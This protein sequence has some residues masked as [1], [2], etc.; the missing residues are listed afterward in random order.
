MLLITAAAASTVAAG[1]PAHAFSAFRLDRTVRQ[2]HPI[3]FTPAPHKVNVRTEG[4][5]KSARGGGIEIQLTVTPYAGDPFECGTGTSVD[6][7][8]GEQVNICYRL[9]NNTAQTLTHQTVEDSVDGTLM[10]YE[11]HAIPAGQQ[12]Y[13]VR[14]VVATSDTTR[15]ATWTGYS[16]VASYTANDQAAPS[17]VDI[18]TTGTDIGFE[19]GSPD[20]N[21][22]AEVTAGFPIRFYGRESSA[23]CVSIDGFIGY[24]DPVCD[25]PSPGAKPQP[26]YS[27]NGD[28]PAF[29]GINVPGFIAPMWSNLGGGGDL[30]DSRVFVQTLGTA[31][32]RRFIVQW[33]DL[34]TYAIASSRA[35][36][37]VVFAEDSDTIRY[38]YQS[39][40]FG[41][42]AD[43]GAWSTVG[44]QGDPDGLFTKYSYYQPSLRPNSAIVWSYTASAGSSA[45]SGEVTISAGNPALAVA[46]PSIS[47]IV[48][49]G[50]SASA[51]MTV[52]NT[53]NRDLHWSL[54]EAPGGST[55]HFPKSPRYIA[56][57]IAAA[58]FA[59]GAHAATMQR[60]AGGAA[61]VHPSV[62][63]GSGG[64]AVPAY[65]VSSTRTGVASFD[66]LDPLDTYTPVNNNND[67]INTAAF[68]GND[69]GK[70]WTII[71]DS[72]EPDWVGSY[73]WF[74]TV[75][76]EYNKVG[77]ITGVPGR[78][79]SWS[80]MAQDP[81]NGMVYAINFLDEPFAPNDAT[82]YTIDMDSGLA[83]RIG[84]IDGP[85]IHPQHYISS[86]AIS[87]DGLLYAIDL[88]AQTLIAIDKNTGQAQPIGSLGLT[89]PFLQQGIAFDQA[90]GDLY[91]TALYDNGGEWP[92][93]EVRVIDPISAQSQA[94]GELPV[95][96]NEFFPRDQM[97]AL[98]IAKPGVGCSAPGSVPWLGLGS[99]AS[100]T[101]AAGAAGQDVVLTFDAS[102]LAPG[103]YQAN[104]CVFSD[105]PRHGRLAVPVS[106]AVVDTSAPIYDQHVTD[107]P[108]R[109]WNNNVVMPPEVPAGLDANGADDFV[110]DGLGW[111]LTGFSFTA[112]G[113]SEGAAPPS[114]IDL[115]VLADGGDGQPGEDVV[116]AANDLGVFPMAEANQIAAILP[117]SC[118][119]PAGTYW[120][121]W[122]FVGL[123]TES[124]ERG[125]WGVSTQQHNQLAVWRNP[126]GWIDDAC[127]TWTPLAQ[128]ANQTDASARDFSFTV[129]ATPSTLDCADVILRDGFDGDAGECAR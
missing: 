91:W 52:L 128:C 104:V 125:Y 33:N 31:P 42:D 126:L 107:T 21:D 99:A 109:M 54:A 116:C 76:G 16:T 1:A 78:N 12:D 49:P 51:T 92:Q 8:V 45:D 93:S 72:W 123:T 87:P 84:T 98:S 44:L 129:F 18:S 41:N 70:L 19:P 85:G 62:A 58:P 127:P 6:V 74:D 5:R 88:A 40:A 7:R 106:L 35:T 73:G 110:V 28:I 10:A 27:F 94:L 17:F 67:W 61:G 83:T 4:T 111:N 81:L 29:Y 68:I 117:Q 80:G 48:A 59:T 60:P 115:R 118:H 89:V 23:L 108:L 114:R 102:G 122:A 66:A 112:Y 3:S 34:P 97:T 75:T 101:I 14:S 30:D 121:S 79:Q 15:S 105:D 82:L 119:L 103:L 32:N 43:N 53:G 55:A 96:S 11:P 77:Y 71:G 57:G 113:A 64:F 86:L 24:D 120:V 2:A 25:S 124:P 47:A 46:Q 69:F 65:G 39:V 26:G 90:T 63:R 13:F 95:T 38:E 36:F 22:F 9:I 20:R 56:P 50:S 37:Q 100:G